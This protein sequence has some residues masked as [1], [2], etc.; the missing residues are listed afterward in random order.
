MV[1]F[2]FIKLHS[3]KGMCQ[4][5]EQ[6]CQPEAPGGFNKNEKLDFIKL[7][8]A[9]IDAFSFSAAENVMG[10]KCESMTTLIDQSILSHYLK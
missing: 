6:G 3:I 9:E 1:C 10:S 8:V 7:I 2:E 5:E 4:S